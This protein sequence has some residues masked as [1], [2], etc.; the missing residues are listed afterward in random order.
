MVPV[1]ENLSAEISVWMVGKLQ[2]EREDHA[3]TEVTIGWWKGRESE[4]N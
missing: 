4:F 3:D 1:E 2:E